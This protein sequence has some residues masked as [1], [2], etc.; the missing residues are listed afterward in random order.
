MSAAVGTCHSPS[1]EAIDRCTFGSGHSTAMGQTRDERLLP[2]RRPAQADP[3]RASNFKP[4]SGHSPGVAWMPIRGSA[5]VPLTNRR[6]QAT[7]RIVC[8]RGVEVNHADPVRQES[9]DLLMDAAL[10]EASGQLPP[11]RQLTP[12][13]AR[14]IDKSRNA[15]RPCAAAGATRA[16]RRP[17]VRQ[18]PAAT[19]P[20]RYC[21]GPGRDAAIK[22]AA[23]AA[24]ARPLPGVRAAGHSAS[25]AD[26]PCDARSGL[27]AG[28]RQQVG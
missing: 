21:R 10:E 26:P 9:A 3:E 2:P 28:S 17:A 14:V 7:I 4:R 16:V 5:E 15:P 25:R 11:E 1:G 18:L 22:A 20:L 13:G 24:A 19:S 27:G 12:G 6:Q 23:R 8:K